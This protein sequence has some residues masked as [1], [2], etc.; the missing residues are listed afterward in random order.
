MGSVVRFPRRRHARASRKSSA[1]I[2][3]LLSF[4]RQAASSQDGMDLPRRMRLMVLRSQEI[5][6]VLRTSA[7]TC[8]SSKSRSNMKADSCMSANVHQVHI[9]VKPDCA[10]AGM[11]ACPATVHHLHMS[12]RAKQKIKKTAA[13]AGYHPTFMR[14]WRED[15]KRTLEDLAE[16]CGKKHGQISRIERGLQPYSQQVLETYARELDCSVVDLLTREPGQAESFLS[17]WAA[18]DE[19]DRKRFLAFA[20]AG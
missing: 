14:A 11:E 18:M 17:I 10:Q 2:L 1:E 8:S 9:A 5:S 7:A 6:N 4:F 13:K 16:K 12:A 3:P 20:K 19:R 15:R